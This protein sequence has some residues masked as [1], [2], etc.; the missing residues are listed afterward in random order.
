MLASGQNYTN[1]LFSK[2]ADEETA[3]LNFINDS[4]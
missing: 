3:L 2:E 1:L 4:F